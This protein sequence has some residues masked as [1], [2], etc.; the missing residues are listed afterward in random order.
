MRL[1]EWFLLPLAGALIGYVTNVIAIRMLFRPRAPL[2]VPGTRWVIQGLIPRRRLEIA[3]AVGDT[4]E[5][6]L[7]PVDQLLD[8]LN[9]GSYQGEVVGAVTDHVERRV[10]ASL[11]RF[12]PSQLQDTLAGFI[13]DLAGRE[14]A[15]VFDAAVQA[16]GERVRTELRIGELVQQKVA[17]LD[18]DALEQL[19]LRVSH[20]ELRYIEGFGALLGLAI[21]LGQVMLLS[22]LR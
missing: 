12:L 10:R 18:L 3:K 20:Q 22:L 2:A 15:G 11:P 4:V 16:L 17:E 1:S 8:K 21:G 7:L 6:D 19:V 5:Q 14:V 13:R 9:I